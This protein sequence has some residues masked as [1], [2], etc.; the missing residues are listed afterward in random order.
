MISSVIYGITLSQTVTYYR[1]SGLKDPRFLKIIVFVLWALDTLHLILCIITVYWYLITNFSNPSALTRTVWALNG[2]IGLIVECFFA[3]RVWIL[4]K[5]IYITATI[6]ILSLL[7]FVFGI[8]F[9]VEEFILQEFSRFP[10]L[11]WIAC[12]GLGSAAA[13]DIIIAASMCWYLWKSRTGFKGTDSIIAT[14]MAYSINTGLLTSI[15]ATA[16]VITFAV[17]PSSFVW[18]SCFWVLGKCYVNSFL[19]TLNNREALR[20]RSNPDPG[21]FLNMST[22]S[23]NET[24]RGVPDMRKIVVQST[25][26]LAVAV[27]RTTEFKTDFSTHEDVKSGLGTDPSNG[28]RSQ[29]SLERESPA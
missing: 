14:L 9:T 13:T 11:I 18:L 16:A 10:S 28:S 19:A 1:Q 6:V 2:V 22:F 25:L 27:E 17:L 26:P 20:N 12:A 7:H 5:N 23:R 3:R 21:N 24:Y 29:S 15:I 4:G 8:V